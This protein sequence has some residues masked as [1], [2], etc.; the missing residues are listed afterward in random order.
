MSFLGSYFTYDGTTS[1]EYGLMLVSIDKSIRE[2]PSGS[3]IEIQNVSVMRNE[4]K[5]ILGIKEN[6]ALEFPIE[7]VSKDP[8]DLPTFLRIKQWL[9]GVT[10]YKKLQIEEEYYSD[11]YYNCIIKAIEDI[12]I[13]GEYYGLRCNVECDSP[14]A[15]TFPLTKEYKSDKSISSTGTFDNFSAELYGLKPIIEFKLASNG[16]SFAIDN[17]TTGRA[18][19][20]TGLNPKEII[21][22]DNKNQIITSSTGL[23]R[24]KNMSKG[25]KKLQKSGEYR[26]CGYFYLEHGINNLEFIGYWEYLKIEY[27]IC[28]RLGGG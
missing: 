8:I 3:G 2:V 6:Q 18:F 1:R 15:Y 23:N 7:I 28:V 11:F 25:L 16:S 24:F 22:I 10:G 17:K 4:R 14:Y 20:M 19:E 12:T 26:N 9:F 27:Q 5:M 21:K 13:G